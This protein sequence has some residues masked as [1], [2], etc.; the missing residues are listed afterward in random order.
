MAKRKS[1][2]VKTDMPEAKVTPATDMSLANP[3]ELA[4]VV[5]DRA[6]IETV[7]IAECS[8][9]RKAQADPEAS[10]MVQEIEIQSIGI[11]LHEDTKTLVFTPSFLLISK[12]EGRPN[13]DA[14]LRLSCEFVV[15]YTCEDI[16][17]IERVNLDAFAHTNVIFNVWPYWREFVQSMTG[18]L[19]FRAILIPLFRFPR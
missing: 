7:L 16:T 12:Q 6:K 11:S 10:D 2:S 1:K 8:A 18:R 3:F 19:G 5:S 14:E 17:G 4:A 15:Q 13:E 9:F